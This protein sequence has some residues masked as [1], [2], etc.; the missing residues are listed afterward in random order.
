VDHVAGSPPRVAGPNIADW[1]SLTDC[2][3]AG[4]TILQTATM[5]RLE[6]DRPS[7]HNS[8]QRMK[9]TLLGADSTA[10]AGSSEN[11]ALE[12]IVVEFRKIRL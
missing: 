1:A 3:V 5:A 6:P 11:T 12:F 10:I 4:Q 9:T 8:M 7:L 2:P